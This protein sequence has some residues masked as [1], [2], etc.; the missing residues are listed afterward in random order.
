VCVVL[1]ELFHCAANLV[2]R[3]EESGAE[4]E[5]PG[6]LMVDAIVFVIC[7]CF[8]YFFGGEDR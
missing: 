6:G 2:L 8:C 4:A 1:F 3:G 7:L 5:A